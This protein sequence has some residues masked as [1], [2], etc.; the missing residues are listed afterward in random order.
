MGLPSKSASSQ[1]MNFAPA[2]LNPQE[3]LPRGFF[4]YLLRLH[5]QFTPW[6][7]KLVAKRAEVFQASHRGQAPN[8]LSASE[9]TTSDWRIEVPDWCSDQRNQMTGPA[10]DGELTV[11]LL[12]SGSPAVMIDLEDST[13]NVW[14]NILLAVKNTIA[15]YKYELS[16]DD[17][18]RNKKVTVQRSK[19]VTWVRPRG[20]HI[21]Q[22]GVIKS[23]LTSASLFDLAL[24][25]YQ[26]DPAW[27]PHNFSVY[28]PK[29]ESAE[30][31]FWWR[32]LFQALAKHKGLPK[33]YIKCMA[34]VEAHP[35][36]YQM[37]EFL[38]NLREHCLGLNLGRWDY[39]ASLIDFMIED[40]NWILP[41]R[42]TIPHDVAFFQNFRTLMPE[43]CHKHA[44]HAIGGMTALFPSRMDAE[45]NER[46]MKVLKQDKKNEADCL[47]DGAWTGHPDQNEIAVAQ[48]PYPNQIAKR[49]RLPS[50]HPDLRPVPKGVGGITLAGT[51]AA[52][53]T[54]IRYRNG[55]LNGKGASLLDGYMEDLATDRIYRL[56]I[57]QRVRHQVKIADDDGRTIEHSSALVTWLFDE[58]LAKIQK[59]LPAEIDRKASG[60]LPEARRIAEQMIVQGWHSPI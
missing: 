27:L 50:V 43:I 3:D 26:I 53:R 42:N 48:F 12:N 23:E 13:A 31:A 38:F 30:E 44:A 11:K 60:T 5:K 41:D 58:E 9:A 52:V 56:M 34:L 45:L 22:G 32:D 47:M 21:S 1:Y 59:D 51:R 14:E 20:L 28:I 24:I 39:M 17:K 40:P 46:A 36:A 25:W 49:P 16:Y 35:L 55:V 4:D 29:S 8:Y 37:E 19:T 2:D 33:D 7:Q 18:K 15:A 57:A 6:Q 10:D 54:V